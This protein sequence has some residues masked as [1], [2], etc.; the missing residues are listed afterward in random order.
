MDRESCARS[1]EDLTK[2]PRGL[3]DNM[4]C[5]LDANVTRKSDSCLGDSGGPLLMI[6]GPNH[7]VV[8]VTAFGQ[9][10]GGSAPSVYTAVYPYLKW[11]EEQVWPDMIDD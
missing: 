7:S 9:K 10:C 11:I 5:A 1:Y 8:G 3:D 6:V 4:L 2:L